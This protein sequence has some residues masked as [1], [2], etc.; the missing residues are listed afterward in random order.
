MVWAVL[1]KGSPP[2]IGVLMPY[3]PPDMTLDSHELMKQYSQ[4]SGFFQPGT[5]GGADGSSGEFPMGLYFV[6]LAFADDLRTAPNIPL[7]EPP[8]LLVDSMKDIVQRLNMKNG[9]VPR[10]YQNVPLERFYNTLQASLFEEK[11]DENIDKD[12][13]ND[14]T[15]PKYRSI[16]ARAHEQIKDFNELLTGYIVQNY[17]KAGTSTSSESSSRK[18]TGSTQFPSDSKRAKGSEGGFEKEFAL[19]KLQDNYDRIKQACENGSLNDFTFE[20]LKEFT[21]KS[22]IKTVST[23]HRGVSNAVKKFFAALES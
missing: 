13:A 15:L 8:G 4:N 1:R 17:M 16:Q 2:K 5:P 19:A 22:Q 6:P 23:T 20:E 12:K 9:Y 18:R 21:V 7:T 11:I 3:M 14:P 10:R